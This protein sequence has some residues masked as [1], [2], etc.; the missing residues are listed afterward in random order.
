VSPQANSQ[1]TPSPPKSCD[2]LRPLEIHPRPI[3]GASGPSATSMSPRQMS[4]SSDEGSRCTSDGHHCRATAGL[5]A[6][7][8]SQTAAKLQLPAWHWPAGPVRPHTDSCNADRCA[9]VAAKLGRRCHQRLALERQAWHGISVSVVYRR[10]LPSKARCGWRS[11]ITVGIADCQL[12]IAR[13][14]HSRICRAAKDR[15]T[16]PRLIWLVGWRCSG[17]ISLPLAWT[18]QIPP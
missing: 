10:P 7:M 16:W 9:Y 11:I 8:C 13:R 17:L 4:F 14:L 15:K 1:S 12:Q 3:G 2:A 6:E 5:Q 18:C